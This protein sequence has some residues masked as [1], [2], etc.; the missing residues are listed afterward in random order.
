MAST[1][2]SIGFNRKEIDILNKHRGDKS[3]PKF[4]KDLV[5]ELGNND[6]N[7]ENKNEKGDTK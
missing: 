3:L 7:M 5:Q 1:Q 2:I 6:N 4:I